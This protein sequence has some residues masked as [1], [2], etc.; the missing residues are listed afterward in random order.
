MFRSIPIRRRD[1]VMF[2]GGGGGGVYFVEK[3]LAGKYL[4]IGPR[5]ELSNEKLNS[6]LFL[7]NL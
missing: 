2:T 7:A 6:P 3:Q 4:T 5:S 1:W